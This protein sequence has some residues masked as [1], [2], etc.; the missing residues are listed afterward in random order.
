[1]TGIKQSER[2]GNNALVNFCNL[3][4]TLAIRNGQ[5]LHLRGLFTHFARHR[6]RGSL[7]QGNSGPQSNLSRYSGVE[8]N[9]HKD[10]YDS[11]S[12]TGV[13]ASQISPEADSE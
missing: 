7:D 8:S 12:E 10:E 4:C 13:V 9:R 11:D 1:M 5:L 6:G 2:R 3:L